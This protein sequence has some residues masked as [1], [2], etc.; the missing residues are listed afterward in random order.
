[1]IK[2]LN[3]LSKVCKIMAICSKPKDSVNK[4]FEECKEI[5]LGAEH[6][7]FY[8][9]PGTKQQ[10]AEWQQLS[11]LADFSWIESVRDI[12][13][14]YCEKTDGAFVEVKE[15]QIVWNYKD[16]DH[17]LGQWQ[18][19]ELGSQIEH[20]LQNFQIE[21]IQGDFYL[22]VIPKQLKRVRVYDCKSYCVEKTGETN[23]QVL[24]TRVAGRFY[25]VHWRRTIKRKSIP[26]PEYP[27]E[28][29]RFE[30]R[31]REEC[32]SLFVHDR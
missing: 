25:S 29:G 18:A 7:F 15:S 19:K 8:K 20:I 5:G 16:T 10:T 27:V 3:D 2:A 14:Q 4:W 11:K 22:E 23:D 31:P 13:R 28:V 24:L 6:G 9:P 17:Q 32:P 30:V 1:M 21:V 12:M 26:L